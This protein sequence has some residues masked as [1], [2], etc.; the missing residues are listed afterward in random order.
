VAKT[1]FAPVGLFAMATLPALL[2]RLQQ[3]AHQPGARLDRRDQAV[4]PFGVR[5][6]A[7][8]PGARIYALSEQGM[9]STA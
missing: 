7:R 6:V 8:A 4:L 3:P 9:S 2:Q 1:E 5:A